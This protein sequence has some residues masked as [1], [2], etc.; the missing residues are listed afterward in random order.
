MDSHFICSTAGLPN[1]IQVMAKNI[2]A[3]KKNKFQ[4][5]CLKGLIL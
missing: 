3:H 5:S 4:K 2:I 1:F